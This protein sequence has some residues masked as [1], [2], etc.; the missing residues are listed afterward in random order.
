MIF[1]RPSYQYGVRA[2]VQHQRGVPDISMSGACD[3]GVD[4]YQSFAGQPPGW[5]VTCGTSEATPL[6][7]GV[8][9]L[10]DQLAGHPIGLINPAL[11]SLSASGA[12]G[13]VDDTSGNNTVTF[14]QSGKLHEIAGFR[15]VRGY[16]LASG[17]GTIDAAKFVPELA[18][19]TG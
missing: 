19:E 12:A 2:V 11:Y 17:V 16:D 14:K 18:R 7:A 6:M 5:Y 1:A 4:M 15:A 9:A 10:V 3:G 8:I 13:I